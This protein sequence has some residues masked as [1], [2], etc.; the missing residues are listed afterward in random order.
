MS[1]RRAQE[2]TLLPAHFVIYD[3]VLREGTFPRVW[4]GGWTAFIP[5][6]GSDGT[7]DSMRGLTINSSVGKVLLKILQRR[8]TRD[9]EDRRVLGEMQHGFRQGYQTIDALYILTETVARRK[10]RGLD[11]AAAFI[12]IKKAYDWV[13]RDV[14]W[15]KLEELG[16]GIRVVGFLRGMYSNNTTRVKLGDIETEEIQIR[17]GLKQG[18]CLSPILFALYIQEISVDLM[19]SG[20]RV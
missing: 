16:F 18:C 13:D 1:L 20:E 5:K 3:T 17:I 14:L 2:T 19:N 4:K 9:V 10:K 7:L 12:D 15:A 8:I 6:P 11:T